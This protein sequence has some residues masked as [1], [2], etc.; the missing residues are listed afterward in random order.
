MYG[1]IKNTQEDHKKQKKKEGEISRTIDYI[2]QVDTHY[3]TAREKWKQVS[4]N[5]TE[6]EKSDLVGKIKLVTVDG[7]TDMLKSSVYNYL[8]SNEM[9]EVTRE[10]ISDVID[11]ALS[12]TGLAQ[13][14]TEEQISKVKQK[15]INEHN[16]SEN[17]FTKQVDSVAD[18]VHKAVLDIN[19]NDGPIK[20]LVKEIDAIEGI[21]EKAQKDVKQPIVDTGRLIRDMRVSFE[22][23]IKG[24]QI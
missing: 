4:E 13:D 9:A 23:E 21:N 6:E 18:E 15:V 22:G 12:T 20:D 16:Y 24:G 2:K 10:N 19:Y 5:L 11:S 8:N 14:L 17:R 7:S 3:D 1:L